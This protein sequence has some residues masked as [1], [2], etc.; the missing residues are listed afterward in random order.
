MV[1]R[2]RRADSRLPSNPTSVFAVLAVAACS[3]VASTF[4]SE[5]VSRDIDIAALEIANN[6]SPSI[7]RLAAA[8]SELRLLDRWSR[9]ASGT[10][11]TEGLTH[12]EPDHTRAFIHA[13]LAAYERLVV[14]PK[15]RDLYEEIRG[16]L[17]DLDTDLR[18]SA[19]GRAHVS[20][21]EFQADFDH[22]SATLQA[23]IGAN[24]DR[25][26]DLAARIETLRR[27][28]KVVAYGLDGLSLLLS[29]LATLLVYRAQRERTQLLEAHSRL[30]EARAEEL[31]QFAGRVAHDIVGPLQAVG[32][33]VTLGLDQPTSP[34][35]RSH[36]ERA[37]RSLRR[38]QQVVHGLL[39][40]ARAAARPEPQAC[41]SVA[42]V[43]ADLAAELLPQ[44]AEARI[45]LRFEPSSASLVRCSPG[46]LV[47]IVSNLTRNAMA[48]ACQVASPRIR[49]RSLE[50]STRV[51]LEVED[52]GPG[53]PVELGT[54]VFEPYVRDA[55]SA[56]PGIGLGL[57]TVK[58]LAQA[59]DGEVGVVSRPGEGCLFWVELPRV[60]MNPGASREASPLHN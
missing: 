52:S 9:D 12:P 58:R 23:A 51:R 11:R 60:E 24:A 30:T 54:S 59:H 32:L 6:T 16:A 1:R 45:D 37:Q 57:A 41:A 7:E 27:R 43:Y 50:L 38:I 19:E 47:S 49:V 34:P 46:V 53:L 39:E 8:R 42:D 35:V 13:Q 28:S 15:E 18:A 56:H 10:A 17:A 44:A 31:E 55:R 29:F 48:H 40:F 14:T 22:V 5:G 21:E 20:R 33:S 36:L 2:R 25:T 4:Y 3:F 26:H